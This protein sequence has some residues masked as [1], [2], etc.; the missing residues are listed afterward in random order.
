VVLN[1]K[2]KQKTGAGARLLLEV[3]RDVAELL[4]DV[5]RDLLLCRRRE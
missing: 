5:A 3:E 4:L 1:P 2:P